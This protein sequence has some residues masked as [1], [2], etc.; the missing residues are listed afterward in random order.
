MTTHALWTAEGLA[1]ACGGTWDG[2]P[3]DLLSGFTLDSRIAEPGDVFIALKSNRD[4]HDF[5]GAAFASGAVAALVSRDYVRSAGDGALLRVDDTQAGLE[6][7]GVGARNRLSPSAY[8]I[9]VTGSVGKTGTKEMLRLAFSVFGATHAPEKSFN[10]H[11]GVPLT[12]ARMAADTRYGVFEIGMNNPGEITPLSRMVRP[13]V[14]IVTTVAPVHLGQFASVDEIAEA[15]AEIFQGLDAEGTAI[16]NRDNA[17][18][19]FLARRAR[20][21]G[22]AV[23]SF[24]QHVDADCRL[25]TAHADAA[26]TTAQVVCLGEDHSL[27]LNVPGAHLVMNA[28]AVLLAARASGCDVAHAVRALE[29]FNVPEGRGVVERI[30][31][32][33]GDVVLIDESYNANP[34]SMAAAISVLELPRAG[35]N[36]RVAIVGD[37]LE[38]GEDGP[39]LHAALAEDLAAAKVNAVFACGPLMAHLYEVLSAE[40]KGGYAPTAEALME[41][42]L[43]A[44]K[45]GDAVMVKGSLGSRMGPVLAALKS[46]LLKNQAS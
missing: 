41:A 12:L 5:V 46:H 1:M 35:V 3:P 36:R 25:V 17:Y 19:D 45:P 13:D 11:W 9:A 15:K 23:L 8:V 7:I 22:A 32:P 28:L 2:A 10:N 37:M 14:A 16:L 4:G 6:A 27:R 33:D 40:Q 38:L 44:V 42:V 43:R 20:A 29:A 34:A 21:R 31:M 26:G 39:A 30:A 24:G 18:F